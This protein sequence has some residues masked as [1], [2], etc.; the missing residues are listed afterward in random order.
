MKKAA[1]LIESTIARGVIPGASLLVARHDDIL[2]EGHW[3][4]YCSRARRDAPV[5]AVT[6]NQAYSFSKGIS[7]CVIAIAH[8]RKLVDYDAPVST[9]LPGFQGK[10]KEQVTLRRLLSHSVG[11][12]RCPSTPV[13]TEAEWQAFLDTCSRY[14]LEWEP[15]SKTLYHASQ[16]MFLAAAAVRAVMDDQPWE[17]ICRELLFD[18]LG[19]P[20]LTFCVPEGECVAVTPQPAT[21]PHT[22][23]Q[24]T[25]DLIGHPGA[26]GF[27][28]ARDM[29]KVMQML[30]GGGTWRGKTLIHPEEMHQLL[31]VQFARERRY[32]EQNNTEPAHE[33]W[34]LGW[35]I[36]DTL[37]NHWFGLGD[38]TSG[39]AFGHAGISTVHSVGDPATG[40]AL[41]YI[42]T[43]QPEKTGLTAVEIATYRNAI[44]DSANA[45]S[46]AKSVLTEGK[47]GKR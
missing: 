9:Y 14:E 16:G 44:T 38:T 30:A 40:L 15:G 29:L 43:D 20:S 21:L 32:A 18:P 22:I 25:F 5:S 23:D 6:V 45:G 26:G 37:R 4:T 33:P 10:W 19:A 28:T 34:G 17:A 35:M 39:R 2:F 3:G 11:M 36:R 46:S 12:S 24:G 47:Q 31:E 41:L 8:Q 42:S 27:G 7:A 13:S 1:E